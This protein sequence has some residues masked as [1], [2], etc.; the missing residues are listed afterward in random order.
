MGRS[1]E[2]NSVI[3]SAD[4][5]RVET[6]L[7][8]DLSDEAEYEDSHMLGG[9]LGRLF[10]SGLKSEFISLS[11]LAL[12][13]MTTIIATNTM[14]TV[15]LI[16][17]ARLGDTQ[18]A[19]VGLANSIFSITGLAVM[20][21]LLT[22]CDTFFTQ[23]YGS[24][25]KQNMGIHLQRA[26]YICLCCCFFCWGVHLSVEPLLLAMKQNPE[27]SKL[28]AEYL[29]YEMPTLLFAAWYKLLLKYIQAQ[30]IV[31]A[32]MVIAITG[33]G[34]NALFH[35]L[36]LFHTGLGI[37]GSAI[38]QSLS[39]ILASLLCI[40][41]LY[42]SK[43]FAT[44][45]GGYRREM[46]QDWKLWFRLAIAG[47]F[48]LAMKWWIFCAGTILSGV[49]GKIELRAQIIVISIDSFI[50][51]AI[52]LGLGIATGIRVG[53][54][55][56][57]GNNLRPKVTMTAA[58]LS[59]FV[60]I[61]FAAIILVTLGRQLCQIFSK[62]ENVIMEA[63]K[64]FPLLAVFIYLDATMGVLTGV[65]RGSGMQKIGAIVI[66]VAF[67][68]VGAPIGFSLLLKTHLKLIGKFKL[69]VKPTVVLLVARKGRMWIGYFIGICINSG[70]YIYICLKIDWEKQVELAAARTRMPE[71]EHL[72]QEKVSWR[73]IALKR[74]IFTLTL[75]TCTV[76]GLI[77]K[78]A[79]PWAEVFGDFCV[80]SN[81]TSLPFARSDQAALVTFASANGCKIIKT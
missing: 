20:Y 76:I 40:A 55:L 22:A 81:G 49:V 14:D 42:F 44:T 51:T 33:N 41:Y 66:L 11:K 6:F 7:D 46:W 43:S 4:D 58:L 25:N 16:F 32:P 19:A 1:R 27:V 75:V 48:M 39:F 77:I 36:L 65:L 63:L 30:N 12:P 37:R 38:S 62:D 52:P 23:T 69:C 24:T 54:A 61:T 59:M 50:F 47:L 34:A 53:Q 31:I 15:S 18:F 10:P 8:I 56:G 70:A 57:A 13:I 71:V 21:G 64:I 3:K 79:P 73:C 26:A 74:A 72:T 5:F 9:C 78:L 29:L 2:H 17:C 68:V 60:C 28:A 67:Y 45:W 80:F 35:Y